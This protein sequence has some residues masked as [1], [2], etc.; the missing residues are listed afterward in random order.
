M[1][2]DALSRPA[3]MVLSLLLLRGLLS[4]GVDPSPYA[5]A[6]TTKNASAT[7]N[8]ASQKANPLNFK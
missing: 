6:P 4:N 7:V 3:K 8:Q 5:T 1:K 2:V